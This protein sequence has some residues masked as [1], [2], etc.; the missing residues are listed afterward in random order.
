ML[1]DFRNSL[2]VRPRSK[3]VIKLSL[4]S[5]P[6]RRS[7][8]TLSCEIFG[9]VLTHSGQCNGFNCATRCAIVELAGLCDRRDTSKTVHS[10]DTETTWSLH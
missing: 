8:A 10:G 6:H 9:V 4:N 3:F 2:T 1:S 7:D 5:L